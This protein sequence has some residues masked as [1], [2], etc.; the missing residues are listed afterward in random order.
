MV[1]Q[2]SIDEFP[3]RHCFWFAAFG[4][5]DISV[6]MP[7]TPTETDRNVPIVFS[8]DEQAK[9]SVRTIVLFNYPHWVIEE[10]IRGSKS[11]LIGYRIGYN[12]ENY[13][14]VS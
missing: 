11:A 4:G 9:R 6:S 7:R 8:D 14:P 10:V 12:H 5:E 13:T 3:N 1:G 2:N